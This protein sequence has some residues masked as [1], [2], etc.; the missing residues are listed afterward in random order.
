MKDLDLLQ[1]N[2]EKLGYY[3]D[4]FSTIEEAKVFFRETFKGNTIGIG[5]SMSVNEMGL[6]PLLCEKNQVEYHLEGGDVD[7]ATR[8]EIYI[9]SVNGV[10]ETGELINI[11]GRGNRVSS[12]IYGTR[13]VYFLVGINKVEP[14]FE[15]ALW[16]A[17][18]IASPKNAK[19]LQRKTPCGVLGDKCYDCNSPERICATLVVHWR[20]SLGNEMHVVLV[21]EDLGY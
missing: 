10:A 2:L 15:K 1:E 7:K 21:E 19:R 13:V 14:T 5:G 4:R 6:Y 12:T 8:C 17:R 11:D 3:V 16:R 9:S 20:P 18:N